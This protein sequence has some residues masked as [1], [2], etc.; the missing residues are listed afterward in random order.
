LSVKQSADDW[1]EPPQGAL[2]PQPVFDRVEPT[3][4]PRRVRQWHQQR[5]D[6]LAA[7]NLPAS[8]VEEPADQRVERAPWQEA[9]VR[10]AT[11]ED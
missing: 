7:S 6:R 10:Q 8:Q 9:L 11:H 5:S 1:A 4:C 3:T 2:Q